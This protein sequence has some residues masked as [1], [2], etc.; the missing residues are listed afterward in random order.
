[1]NVLFVTAY[2]PVLQMHGGGVRMFH[3]IRILAQ[4][5][6]VHLISFVENDAERKMLRTLDP[7]CKTVT[8]VE[9]VPDFRP[10]PL[11]VKPFLVRAFNTAEMHQAIDTIL[12]TADIEVLQCEYLQMAQYRRQNVFTILTIH[13]TASPN[14][15]EAFSREKDP[16]E[17]LR[18][19]YG[20]MALLRYE[21]LQS[22]AFD[23][24]VTMTEDDANYLRSY[25]PAARIRSI[26]IGVDAAEFAPLPEVANGRPHVLF[27]GNFRHRPNA[28]AAAFLAD[29][30]APLIPDLQ[31]LISGPYA[32][33]EIRPRPNVVFSGYVKDTRELYTRPD[34]I[35]AAPLF[36]GTGQ[37]VKLLEAFA[38]GCPV[39]TSSLGAA[40]YPVS[41]GR[42]AL[43]AD[44]I[45]DFVAALRKLAASMDL[46]TQLG[47]NAR[48]MILQHFDWRQLS[49]EYLSLIDEA[50]GI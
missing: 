1:M 17:K 15:Y 3:N 30:I 16:I 35:V 40:G 24:I 32:P 44:S 22:R 42:E 5:H 8:A 25:S 26:P 31:F 39:V 41:N 33:T 4:K 28:E 20:W 19:Y 49:S 18:L 37:R 45:P 47:R 21:V 50:K 36:S 23:R 12:K 6:R 29:R 46:R 11:S 9:R 13:E 38:M 7:F 14:A 43:I 2:P 27:L 34:T 10:H 48:D